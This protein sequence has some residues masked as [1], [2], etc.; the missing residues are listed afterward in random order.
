M[1]SSSGWTVAS[2]RK[3]KCWVAKRRRLDI[4]HLVEFQAH[5]DSCRA[6]IGM[7]KR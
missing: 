1:C 3:N 7:L 5:E 4:S 6:A 2:H